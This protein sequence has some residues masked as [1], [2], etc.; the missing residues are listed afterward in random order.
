MTQRLLWEARVTIWL[1]STE[2]RLFFTM[3]L[4][5]LLELSELAGLETTVMFNSTWLQE[6]HMLIATERLK[7]Y[8]IERDF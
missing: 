4:S 5:Q 7:I 2:P 3:L 1:P 8:G 6:I